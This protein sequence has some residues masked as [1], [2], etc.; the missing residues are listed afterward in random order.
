MTSRLDLE[1]DGT[2]FAGWARQPGQRTVQEEV[3]KALATVLR[4]DSVA[5]TVAG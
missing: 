5:L 1:Y 3:E 2:A 4:E